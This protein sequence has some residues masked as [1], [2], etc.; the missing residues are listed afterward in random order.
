VSKFHQLIF[1]CTVAILSLF[2]RLGNT[3]PNTVEI[4]C[5]K[6]FFTPNTIEVKKAEPVR[7]ILKSVDVTHGFAIDDFEIAREIPAGP[8]TT[9][10][11]TPDRAGEFPF[12]CVVRCGKNH[13]KMR[14][15]L[16]VR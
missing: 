15:T 14:G 16:I 1:I 7:L 10:E 5:Q 4:L 6:S 11:F 12:Y 9:I 2:L 13:L 8:P 3:Q